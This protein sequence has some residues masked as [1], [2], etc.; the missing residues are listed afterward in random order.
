LISVGRRRV[1]KEVVNRGLLEHTRSFIFAIA[2]SGFV[3]NPVVVLL[4]RQG[5]EVKLAVLHQNVKPQFRKP[6]NNPPEIFWL[7]FFSVL[8]GVAQPEINPVRIRNQ[9]LGL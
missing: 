6:N 5:T 8:K 4:K 2:D 3:V 7:L 1:E 9:G